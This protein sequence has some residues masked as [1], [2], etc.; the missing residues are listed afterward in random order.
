MKPQLKLITNTH[1][2]IAGPSPDFIRRGRN[3]ELAA[4]PPVRFVPTIKGPND[5][6]I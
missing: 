6:V 5:V 4:N 2:I 1:R 3:P